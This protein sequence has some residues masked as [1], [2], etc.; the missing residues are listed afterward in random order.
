[1]PATENRRGQVDK[2][3][4]AEAFDLGPVLDGIFRLLVLVSLE[5]T[6]CVNGV[7]LEV[8]KVGGKP[9]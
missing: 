3:G 4:G 1:M 5:L 7:L 8:I 2:P 9:V 6:K